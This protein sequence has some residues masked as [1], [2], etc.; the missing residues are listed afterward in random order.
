MKETFDH[1]ISLGY[2]C[3]T[4][5]AIQA[6]YYGKVKP[7]SNF[8]NWVFCPTVADIIHFLSNPKDLFCEGLELNPS[9]FMY[10][11][12]AYNFSYHTTADHKNFYKNGVLN[13]AFIKTD[14][15][16]VMARLSYLRDK[17]FEALKSKDKNLFV[18]CYRKNKD[19]KEVIENVKTLSKIIKDTSGCHDSKILIVFEKKHIKRLNLPKLDN[20]IYRVVKKHAREDCAYKIDFFGWY[21]KVLKGIEIRNAPK[22]SWLNIYRFKKIY[23]LTFFSKIIKRS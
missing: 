3:Q 17:F 20:V 11:D 2:N 16:H 12:L 23:G 5:F 13:T 19:Q 4:A 9:A 15:R 10:K 14:K 18:L 1:I 7:P 21:F 6:M 8:F 22:K